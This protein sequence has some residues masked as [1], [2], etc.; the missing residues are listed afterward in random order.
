MII[1]TAPARVSA[2]INVLADVT[3]WHYTAYVLLNKKGYA[4]Q[5]KS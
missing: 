4:L 2:A 1:F 3:A 5:N